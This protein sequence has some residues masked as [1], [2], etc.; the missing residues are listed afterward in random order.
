[1][2]GYTSPFEWNQVAAPGMGDAI[3]GSAMAA[4][5][6]SRGLGQAAQIPSSITAMQDANKAKAQVLATTAADAWA[7]QKMLSYGSP[8]ELQ[9]AYSDGSFWADMPSNV[10][11][12]DISNPTFSALGTRGSELLSN[13]ANAEALKESQY[14]YGRTVASNERTDLANQKSEAYQTALRSQDPKAIAQ[15]KLEMDQALGQLT[16]GERNQFDQALAPQTQ[17]WAVG[18]MDTLRKQNND[19]I[20]LAELVRNFN[21]PSDQRQA[22]FSEYERQYKK[23]P[24]EVQPGI[25]TRNNLPLMGTAEDRIQALLSGT[26]SGVMVDG[27]SYDPNSVVGNVKLGVPV[28]TMRIGD[29]ADKVDKPLI[30]ATRGRSDLGLP[31]DKGSS[32]TGLFQFIGST[33]DTYAEK[34]L[35]PNWRNELYTPENQDKMAKALFEDNNSSM[36]SLREQWPSLNNVKVDI[37]KMPWEQARGYIIKGEAARSQGITSAATTGSN[38]ATAAIGKA[39]KPADPVGFFDGLEKQ[40]QAAGGVPINLD[41]VSAQSAV[42]ALNI[43]VKNYHAATT[44]GR[45]LVPGYLDAV[46]DTDS[47]AQ[48]VAE[49]LIKSDSRFAN[50]D[51]RAITAALRAIMQQADT[52]KSGPKGNELPGNMTFALA[53]QILKKNLEERN[54]PNAIQRFFMGAKDLKGYAAGDS[55]ADIQ[56]VLETSPQTAAFA[57]KKIDDQYASLVN[58]QKQLAAAEQQVNAYI[59]NQRMSA[60][61]D[62]AGLQIAMQNLQNLKM[63][64][65]SH[66]AALERITSGPRTKAKEAQAAN[67]QAEADNKA[68][69]DAAAA[70]AARS[71]AVNSGIGSITPA[72]TPES[73][74]ILPPTQGIPGAKSTGIGYMTPEERSRLLQRLNM[75]P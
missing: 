71:P 50:Q 48:E 42:E 32:A 45:T 62:R 8:E 19:P 25:T 75:Q 49:R 5:L 61:P 33:R 64:F 13:A 30:E 15:A 10:V 37:T 65:I 16:V 40:S 70:E 58:E 26:G 6:L 1:M 67:K 56:A 47:S 22:L 55:K 51:S 23:S 20:A 24:F 12:S 29:M 14:K 28:T 69:A 9:K 31:K 34:A 46:N 54:D 2:A 66:A 17:Q 57:K 36:A 27:V 35:G 41:Q 73:L 4:N 11:R 18:T 7:R 3:Q 21:G 74:R 60:N 44:S 52:I 68:K 39:T 72:D 43:G 59:D 63:Q 53:G 38:G